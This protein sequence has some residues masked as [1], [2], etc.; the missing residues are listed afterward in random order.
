MSTKKPRL[1][2]ALSPKTLPSHPFSPTTEAPT[3]PTVTVPSESETEHSEVVPRV[4]G[5]VRISELGPTGYKAGGR[6]PAP[7]LDDSPPVR[8]TAYLT[9]DQVKALRAEVHRRQAK[10]K[11]A[12]LSMLLRE[13]VAAYLAAK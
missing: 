1:D 11:R 13:A 12:D 2:G 6:R 3:E 8:L 9:Q 10:G 5:H 7:D 4:G